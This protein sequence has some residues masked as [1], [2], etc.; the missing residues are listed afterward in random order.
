VSLEAF[1]NDKSDGGS[2]GSEM[3]KWKPSLK[4]LSPNPSVWSGA[5]PAIRN[6]DNEALGL[7][8]RYDL[9]LNSLPGQA[10]FRFLLDQR[11]CN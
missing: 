5:H 3:L 11:S 1:E 2:C 10:S 8:L 4:R 9:L 6:S 7:N